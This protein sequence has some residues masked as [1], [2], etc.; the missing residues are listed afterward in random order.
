MKFFYLYNGPGSSQKC[1]QHTLHTLKLLAQES[2]Q[3]HEIGAKTLLTA[4]WEENCALLVIPGGRDIPY[5][6]SLNGTANT[7]IAAFVA[8]GGSF[9]GICAGSYF[10]GNFV[11]FAQGTIQ[12]VRGSRELGF[13]PGTVTGPL[14]GPYDYSSYSSIHLDSL[15]WHAGSFTSCPLVYNGGGYFVDA[16]KAPKTCVLATYSLGLNYPAIIECRYG[17]GKAILS[18]LHFEY[19]PELLDQ[20]DPYLANITPI[21]KETNNERLANVSQLLSRFELS[22]IEAKKG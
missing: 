22:F 5:C 10:A 4:D 7:K 11:E 17:L 9:L 15:T 20:N 2:Y 3:V 21:L 14:F 19:D 8:K 6:R 12:E 1:V 16:W 18:G 13:F